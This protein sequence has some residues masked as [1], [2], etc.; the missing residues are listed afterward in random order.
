MTLRATGALT[1]QV[2]LRRGD[3]DIGCETSVGLGGTESN[4]ARIP[5]SQSLLTMSMPALIGSRPVKLEIV[6]GVADL[7]ATYP[8]SS[9][10]PTSDSEPRLRVRLTAR[11]E[12]A[13]G[14][15][16]GSRYSWLGQSGSVT[17]SDSKGHADSA[18][19]QVWG[20]MDVSL[21][22]ERDNP[23]QKAL[24]LAGGWLCDH[25]SVP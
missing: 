16:S 3:V 23:S 4:P 17:I 22:A 10:A 21:N 18:G 7:V 12:G 15:G 19:G 24:H 25:P 11:Q 13:G 14:V 6:G 2:Q 8:V 20:T 9:E 5:A 1:G